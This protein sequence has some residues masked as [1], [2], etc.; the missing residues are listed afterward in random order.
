MLSKR[1]EDKRNHAINL[2]V[3]VVVA[4]VTMSVFL[5]PIIAYSGVLGKV[6]SYYNG[7]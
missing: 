1:I 6:I 2:I 7:I 5:A 3:L 4:V